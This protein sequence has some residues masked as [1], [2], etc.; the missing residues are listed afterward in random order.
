MSSHLKNILIICIE[1]AHPATESNFYTKLTNNYRTYLFFFGLDHSNKADNHYI[2]ENKI[3]NWATRWEIQDH[4]SKNDKYFQSLEANTHVYIIHDA[5][6]KND[7]K[8]LDDTYRWVKQFLIS[9]NFQEFNIHRIYDEG[10]NFD[11]FLYQI[12]YDVSSNQTILSREFTKFAKRYKHLEAKDDL[13]KNIFEHYQI[14]KDNEE[15]DSS[16]IEFLNKVTSDRNVSSNHKTI[17]EDIKSL[18][19]KTK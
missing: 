4:I 2:L 8:S 17:L 10:R 14:N 9:M 13:W 16:I 3:Q 1:S 15:S 7:M 18:V 11:Y 6:A 5:D 12:T 19:T